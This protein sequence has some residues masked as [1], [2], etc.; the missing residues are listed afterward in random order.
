MREKVIIKFI[1][2]SCTNIISQNQLTPNFSLVQELISKTSSWPNYSMK[3]S[4]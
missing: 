3:I 1:K 2:N 4:L